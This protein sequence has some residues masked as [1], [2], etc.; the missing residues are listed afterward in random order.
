M[1]L[2]QVYELWDRFENSS[3]N[4]FEIEFQGVRLHMKKGAAA[5][6]M[7]QPDVVTQGVESVVNNTNNTTPS[8]KEQSGQ[9]Q[10]GN[11]KEI[12]APIVGTFYRAPSPDE[13]PFVEV[14]QSVKK[15]NVIGIIEAMKLMNEVVAGEDGIVEEILADDQSFVEYNQV[16]MRMK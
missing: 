8:E 13:K 3:V 14:G 11:L 9:S 16:L 6:V 4:D 1:E 12:L 2:K 5:P 10:A 15:G 7:I